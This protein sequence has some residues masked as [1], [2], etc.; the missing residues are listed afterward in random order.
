MSVLDLHEVGEEGV[1]GEAFDEV[2]LSFFELVP[3]DFSIDLDERLGSVAKLLFEGVNGH[4]VGD[5][6]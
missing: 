1:A 4:G 3:E 2:F 6:L 5:V